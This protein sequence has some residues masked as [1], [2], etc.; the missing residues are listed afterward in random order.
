[1]MGSVGKPHEDPNT[2]KTE[3][4]RKGTDGKWWWVEDKKSI[5][6]WKHVMKKGFKTRKQKKVKGPIRES[7]D[8][9][10]HIIVNYNTAGKCD[11]KSTKSNCVFPAM[12]ESNGWSHVYNEGLPENETVKFIKKDIY[13]G[14][15]E[16]MDTFKKQLFVHY[17]KYKKMGYLSEFVII[18]ESMKKYFENQ[19]RW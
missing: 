16:N 2:L 7:A 14:P 17:N 13:T 1:M 19:G 4:I 9:V 15:I 6:E 3:A 12:K 5:H 11:L 10:G 18:S 8:S